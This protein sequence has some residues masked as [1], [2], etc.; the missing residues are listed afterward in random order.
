MKGI[1]FACVVLV[2]CWG[3]LLAEERLPAWRALHDRGV[4]GDAKAV[5]ECIETLEAVLAKEPD[6][7]LALVYLGSAYTLRSRDLWI[8]P[9]KLETLKRGGQ[10]MDQAVAAQPDNPRVRLIRA[11]NSLKLPRL[12][13]RRKLALEDF[14]KLLRQTESLAAP[15]KQALYYFAGLALKGEGQSKRAADLWRQG[16]QLNPTS[17]VAA[18]I[19]AE[20]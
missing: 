14:E 15:E 16:L 6:N 12:F 1:T 10:L 3:S 13:N 2:T 17:E 9:K 7:Q 11:V 20:L 5:V 8:G 18:K 4:Q 19:K